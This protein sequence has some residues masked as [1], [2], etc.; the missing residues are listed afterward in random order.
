[1]DQSSQNITPEESLKVKVE[2]CKFM[3]ESWNYA[4]SSKSYRLKF[5]KI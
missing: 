3:G 2:L 4:I 1:M 5:I